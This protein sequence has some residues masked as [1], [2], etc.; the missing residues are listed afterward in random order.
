[1]VILYLYM[2][3]LYSTHFSS[4]QTN[5]E[6]GVKNL[7]LLKDIHS[8][9]RNVNSEMRVESAIVTVNGDSIPLDIST[10]TNSEKGEYI[11]TIIMFI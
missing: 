9:T 7:P 10:I 3:C 5:S 4:I 11:C 8:E 2:N 6:M 1:M